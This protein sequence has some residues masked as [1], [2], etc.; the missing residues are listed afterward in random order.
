MDIDGKDAQMIKESG[1]KLN[2]VLRK[3]AQRHGRIM[4]SGIA[5]AFAGYG[6]CSEDPFFT[7][8]EESCKTQGDFEGTMHPNK[9]GH[10]AL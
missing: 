8:A 3:A 6:R 5:D 10:R 4:V 2:H 1:K 7:S 9:K